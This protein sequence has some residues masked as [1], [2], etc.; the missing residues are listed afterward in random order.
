MLTPR[1][2]HI[3]RV[4][5][6][7]QALLVAVIDTEEEFDWNKPFS[8]TSVG[9][10]HMQYQVRAQ[11]IFARF[12]LKPLYAIDYPVAENAQG[13]AALSEWARS[14]TCEIGTH[15]HPWVN[16]PFEEPV[17]NRNS[18]PGNLPAPLERAKL[19]RLTDLIEQRFGERPVVYRAGRYGVGPNTA[20]TLADLGYQVDTSV[21]PR[22]DFSAEE[23][24]DF[25]RCGLDPYW[26]DAPGGLLEVPLTVGWTGA[27]AGA[28]A[29]L[30]PLCRSDWGQRLRLQ[31]L[32][33]RA[34]LFD[35]IR[36]TPEGMSIDELC[37]LTRALFA[38]G[39]RV[40]NFTY[41]SPSLMPGNTPYVRSDAELEIFLG[42]IERY[43]EFFFGVIGGR[44]ATL[45][46]IRTLC[47]SAT[48]EAGRT[49]GANVRPV[50][51]APVQT[52]S[53]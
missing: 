40:F 17:S 53:K 52:A 18:Y 14:G 8:R 29:T 31:G 42:A 23:G 12:G 15:L 5:E 3:A 50:G 7:Q 34:G 20:A 26:I 1:P 22:T 37:H 9:V 25:R 49:S 13:Y 30:Q 28:G 46:E 21:V 2:D 11:T 16:P 39:Q 38:R 27:L 4:P 10:A 6:T 45:P 41:H 43:L 19:A 36:L 51:A 32:L 44:A 48:R 24:P 47:L 33:S 35:R